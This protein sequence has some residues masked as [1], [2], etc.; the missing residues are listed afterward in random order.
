[1]SFTVEDLGKNMIKLTIECPAEEFEA[2]IEKA[3]HKNKNKI[4]VPGFR[5]GKAPLSMIEKLYGPEMFYEDAANSLIPEAYEKAADECEQEIVSRPEIDVVNIK[6]G[7]KFVFTATV[8]VKPE[9]T[10]GTYKGVEVKKA[11]IEVTDEEVEADINRTRE[12]NAKKVEVT[13]RAI[14][15][16]DET[17]IDFEGFVDGVA[18]EGGK[19][20]DYPL[21]I[22]SGAFIPG[23]E[24]Q[25]IGKNIGEEFDVN[26]TFPEEYHAKDLAGKPA[27]FKVTVK[28]AT[29]KVLPELD[30][31]YVDET[32]EFSTVAEYREDVKK[33][34]LAAKEKAA[35]DA[36]ENEAV[37]KA[38]ANA[39]IDIP[40]GMIEAQKQQVAE[41]FSYRLQSQG[42]TI[43]QYM[44]FTGMDQKKFLESLEPQAIARIR[45][46]LT[47]EA[48]VAAEGIEA[49][50][51]EFEAEIAEMGKMY[52]MDSDKV[53]EILG[54]N[55]E[56]VKADIAV[57]KAA[58]L[59]ADNAV[60]VEASAE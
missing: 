24:E 4:N 14:E 39:T 59:L 38:A 27:V 21:V 26:V 30:D 8:A 51:E 18:F 53:K 15:N 55:A 32:T 3:Y 49:T 25:I 6:K 16:G 2:A 29:T 35:A 58:K 9:V 48:V 46:R 44:Q 42:L 47:L 22:G 43:E 37:E 50:E 11:V 45:T 10:L 40:Q 28:S 56:Q 17:V 52:N 23:F 5:K 7:E 1:M 36:K 20:T 57:K 13:D 33:N 34:I 31:A 41:E 12:M 54:A 19:G 60:E